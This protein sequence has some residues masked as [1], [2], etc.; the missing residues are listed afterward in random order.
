MG[1][2]KLQLTLATCDKCAKQEET[3]GI[4]P[5]KPHDWHWDKDWANDGYDERWKIDVLLCPECYAQHNK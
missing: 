3:K 1:L 5:T 4:V 2:S